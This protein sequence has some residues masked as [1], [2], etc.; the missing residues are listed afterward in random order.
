MSIADSGC[1]IYPYEEVNDSG[2]FVK[3]SSEY[4]AY[5][6]VFFIGAFFFI[7]TVI[8]FLISNMIY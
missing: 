2:E 5:T 4:G 3:Y 1:N 8:C 6:M 7:F